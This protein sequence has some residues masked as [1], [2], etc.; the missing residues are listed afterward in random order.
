MA[1]MPSLPPQQDKPHRKAL[2][3]LRDSALERWPEI[4]PLEKGLREAWRQMKQGLLLFLVLIGAPVALLTYYLTH[5]IDGELY[6]ASVSV[7]N[8]VH[9]GE[10]KELDASISQLKQKVQGLEQDKNLLRQERDKSDLQAQNDRNALAPWMQLANSQFTNAPFNQ[11]LDL[12]F[13]HVASL[14]AKSPRFTVFVNDLEITNR[15][16]LSLSEDR[17]MIIRV[18]NDGEET[19]PNITVF[20]TLS[21]VLS[22]P[23]CPGWQPISGSLHDE[24]RKKLEDMFGWKVVSDNAI[25][26]HDSFLAPPFSISTNA[27]PL[28][29]VGYLPDKA[30]PGATANITV[31]STNSK[32]QEITFLVVY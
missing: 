8:V 4:K 10:I 5:H 18:E 29:V 17:K 24:H 30:V 16:I 21:T 22:N 32:K 6:N 2:A 31:Y 19:A 9:K 26:S 11:R 3:I 20:L 25:A 23:I 1:E 13:E 7:T 28:V 15:M 27:P 12:L 14:E